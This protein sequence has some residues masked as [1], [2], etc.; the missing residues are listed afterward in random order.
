[1][2]QE[3][4]YLWRELFVNEKDPKKPVSRHVQERA[5]CAIFSKS[6][7]TEIVRTSPSITRYRISFKLQSCKRKVFRGLLSVQFCVSWEPRVKLKSKKKTFIKTVGINEDSFK[8]SWFSLLLSASRYNSS[9][10]FCDVWFITPQLA[11]TV[12]NK[13][14]GKGKRKEKKN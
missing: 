7:S 11:R 13:R 14:G 10:R 4:K 6:I 1:M 5:V 3:P 8:I 2:K 9:F 12:Y